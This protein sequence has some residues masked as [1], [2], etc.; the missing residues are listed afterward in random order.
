MPSDQ[1]LSIGRAAEA[2]GT[3]V[4]TVRYYDRCGLLADLGRDAAGNRRFTADD[5]GWLRV[6]R[7][8]RD[9]GMSIDDLRRFVAVDARGPAGAAAR[10]ERL[11]AH[12]DAVRERIRRTEAELAVVAVKIEAYRALA[13]GTGGSVPA[14]RR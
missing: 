6:L 4:D 13:A 1:V 2:A 11:E 5:V 8:L 10:L 12:R 14:V 3:T 9:T 7:C